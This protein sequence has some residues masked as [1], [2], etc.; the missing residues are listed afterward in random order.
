MQVQLKEAYGVS[1]AMADCIE[2]RIEVLQNEKGKRKFKSM[3]AIV[4]EIYSV[5]TGLNDHHN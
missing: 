4:R 2:A 1:E 5:L 3:T